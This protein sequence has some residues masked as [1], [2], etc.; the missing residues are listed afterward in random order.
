MLVAAVDIFA[1]PNCTTVF[2]LRFCRWAC[3]DEAEKLACGKSCFAPTCV[4]CLFRL[5]ALPPPRSGTLVRESAG[6]QHAPARDAPLHRA[7]NVLSARGEGHPLESPEPHGRLP[8]LREVLRRCDGLEGAFFSRYHICAL[9]F[10]DCL[11]WPASSLRAFH[12]LTRKWSVARARGTT[13]LPT[14]ML[15]CL[16]LSPPPQRGWWRAQSS[17]A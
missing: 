15:P 11:S 6:N 4:L 14:G 16:P 8:R 9:A 3:A 2:L 7:P 1:T 12:P 10:H 5:R 17:Q 13:G